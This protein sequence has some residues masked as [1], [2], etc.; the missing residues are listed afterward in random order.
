MTRVA[1]WLALF[2]FAGPYLLKCY[3]DPRDC[4]QNIAEQLRNSNEA[5]IL[6]IK[7]RDLSKQPEPFRDIL[8][9]RAL[10][11]RHTRILLH[12]PA[13]RYVDEVISGVFQFE[14]EEYKKDLRN[15][16]R[17]LVNTVG[18]SPS[19]VFRIALYDAP[20][21]FKLFMFDHKMYVGF[22]SAIGIDQ[23]RVKIPGVFCLRRRSEL[24]GLNFVVESHFEYLWRHA[25][26]PETVF[27]LKAE[28]SVLKRQAGSA[29]GKTAV[30]HARLR[31]AICE[32]FDD[33]EL[34]ILCTD[35]QV[36]Y[37]DL[38]GKGKTNKVQALISY[39]KRRGRLQELIEICT[40]RRPH[41]PWKDLPNC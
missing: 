16:I 8:R 38:E 34:R 5:A 21:V 7:G 27:D 39:L 4:E 36:D 24:P 31:G 41:I 12:S 32:C 35:I 22:Y 33:R 19:N 6:S 3:R 40:E 37:D 18:N 1:D 17:R 20:P 30:K 14:L 25:V 28:E 26:P 11:H 15:S 10:T 9:E 23:P 2:R 29:H 13:S